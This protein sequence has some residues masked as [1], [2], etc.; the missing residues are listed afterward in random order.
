MGR[1][2]LLPGRQ[3]A[4]HAHPQP[5]R[6]GA[7]GHAVSLPLLGTVLHAYAAGAADRTPSGAHRGRHRALAR[8]DAGTGAGGGDRRRDAVRGRLPHRHVRQMARGRPG[9]RTRRRTRASIMLITDSTT[10]PSIPGSTRTRSTSRRPWTALAIS[11]TSPA[12]LKITA[13]STASRSWARWKASRARAGGRSPPCPPSPWW[14]WR[15]NP[16]SRSRNSSGIRPHRTNRFSCTGRLMPSRWPHHRW[17]TGSVK[18]R[19]PATTRPRNWPSTTI[20]SAS[21]LIR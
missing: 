3:A 4:R 5:G 12:P 14:K 9:A 18:G 17:I 11:M 21:C 7:T 2:G 1:T 6:P 15:S 10:A 13:T 8:A 16:S 19:I 20:M